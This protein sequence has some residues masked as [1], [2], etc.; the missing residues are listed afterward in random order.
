MNFQGDS[1]YKTVYGALLSISIV[2]F[3]S[4]SSLVSL[5][6]LVTKQNPDFVVNTVLKDML[7]DY[8]KPFNAT[9][10][11]FEFGVAYASINPYRFVELD[12][13]IARISMSRND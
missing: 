7:L 4:F 13:R 12:P 6:R 10:K 8:D 5:T 1:T 9:E 3:V 11:N 2:I